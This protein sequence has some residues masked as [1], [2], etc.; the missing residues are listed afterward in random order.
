[1]SALPVT[2]VSPAEYLRRERL[3]E[4]RN[5]YH[6]GEIVAMSGANRE[7]NQIV[8]NITIAL[9]FQLRDRPCSNYSNDMRVSVRGGER[10]YYPD[11]V[12]TCGQEEFEDGEQ[13]TLVNPLVIMEVLS[14][15]TE[16]FDRGKKFHD[17]QTIPSLREYVLVSPS[18][19]RLEVYRKQPDG[20]WL[21]QSSPFSPPPL[22]LQSI[23]CALTPDE[24][25]HK[26]EEEGE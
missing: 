20:T 16:R 9:G 10:Y 7:H 11:I 22:V 19:R 15:S 26:V 23:D 1:M 2:A 5:E 6:G 18:P 25:Y 3:A 24:V 13:D 21:Y 12:V 14:P 4:F 17:Y 8:V